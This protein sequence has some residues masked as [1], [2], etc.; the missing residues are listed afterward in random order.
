V[1]VEGGACATAQ[2]HN[3]QSKPAQNIIPCE[4]FTPPHIALSSENADTVAMI[5]PQCDVIQ[6][7]FAF[8][9][10]VDLHLHRVYI[11]VR[12]CEN[13]CSCHMPTG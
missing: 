13:P 6:S 8:R 9:V 2:W 11:L 12:P 1:F 7:N 3:G 4:K 10:G 5:D